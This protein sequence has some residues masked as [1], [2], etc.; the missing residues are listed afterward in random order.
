MSQ[1]AIPADY[2]LEHLIDAHAFALGSFDRHLLLELDPSRLREATHVGWHRVQEVSQELL[3]QPEADQDA[4]W[5]SYVASRWGIGLD[6]DLSDKTEVGAAVEGAHAALQII[7]YQLT[8]VPEEENE[9]SFMFFAKGYVGADIRFF[10]INAA[11]HIRKELFKRLNELSSDRA[12]NL[13]HMLWRSVDEV[14][15]EAG[16]AVEAAGDLQ[17]LVT[18]FKVLLHASAERTAD[19]LRYSVAGLDQATSVFLDE[20]KQFANTALEES[21]T[22]GDLE[23]LASAST[24]LEVFGC[25]ALANLIRRLVDRIHE[26]GPK[27][28]QPDYSLYQILDTKC[29]AC[30]ERARDVEWDIINI[31]ARPHLEARVK[32][33]QAVVP[34]CKLCLAELRRF[35]PLLYVN[36]GRNLYLVLCPDMEEEHEKGLRDWVSEYFDNLPLQYRDNRPQLMFCSQY[37]TGFK[38]ADQAVIVCRVRSHEQFLRIVKRHERSS[39]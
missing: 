6:V 21:V 15:D 23:Y 9:N 24:T 33:G 13:R 16:A 32:N 38:N 5:T 34:R 27:E 31:G 11:R 35:G 26:L 17:E 36:P 28:V 7:N 1:A 2:T 39:G 12:R 29:P 14:V 4:Y 3:R 22:A 8:L 10:L 25:F 20:L 19:T 30:L 18:Y 37:V